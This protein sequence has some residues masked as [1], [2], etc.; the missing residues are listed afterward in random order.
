MFKLNFN[1]FQAY[2]LSTFIVPKF[3]KLC[4]HLTINSKKS[5]IVLLC[6]LK[7][8]SIYLFLLVSK[9]KPLFDNLSK[10]F[11]KDILPRFHL[12]VYYWILLLGNYL[13]IGII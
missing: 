3:L 1:H 10:L 7:L 2:L 9:I 11:F 12:M 4:N 6:Y 13:F 8:F 5:T